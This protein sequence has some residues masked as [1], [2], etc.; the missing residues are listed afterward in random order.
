[1][2][3][4]F[5]ERLSKIYRNNKQGASLLKP[6]KWT[7][8][9]VI[10]GLSK[11]LTDVPYLKMMYTRAFN[12]PLYLGN[13]QTFTEKL[14]WLKL[15]DKNPYKT[16]CADK[17]EVRGYVKERIGEQYLIPLLFSSKN[18]RE[19]PFSHLPRNYII[20][21]NHGSGG[22][23]IINGNKMILNKEKMSFN[24]KLIFKQLDKWLRTDF[25]R[26]G[27]E[28]EYRNISRRVIVEELLSDESENVVLN[29]YKFHCFN[30]KSLYVQTITDRFEGVK[31][32]WFTRDWTSVDVYYFSKIRKEI[33]KPENLDE[34]LSLAEKLS[35]GFRYVRVDLYSITGKPYF[36]EMTFHPAGGFMKFVPKE[37]DLELGRYLHL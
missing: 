36:G 20:K 2:N 4:W 1:M 19:I 5:R 32:N 24:D 25:S 17:L 21:T 18:P 23:V 14:Q 28:W 31:E 30:G 35:D 33:K 7:E 9:K 37:F 34:M 12:K 29:D 16:N 10:H 13:P 22:N 11:I 15:Y 6:L 27:R 8:G 26:I 3:R